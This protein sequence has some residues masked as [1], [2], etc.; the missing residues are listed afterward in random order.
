[1]GMVPHPGLAVQTLVLFIHIKMTGLHGRS[2][3]QEDGVL[4]HPEV[5]GCSQHLR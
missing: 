5:Q 2:S 3:S 4:T 1:M